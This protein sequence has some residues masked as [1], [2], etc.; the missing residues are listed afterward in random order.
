M[1]K[2]M[3]VLTAALALMITSTAHAWVYGS[4]ATEFQGEPFTT[5]YSMV[6]WWEIL[7]TESQVRGTFYKQLPPGGY[8]IS[9]G[10]EHC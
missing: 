8:S 1:E 6:F 7:I 5:T 2:K 3:R 9:T 10:M 4:Y